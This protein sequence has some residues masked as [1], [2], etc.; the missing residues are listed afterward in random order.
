VT[1]QIIEINRKL[2]SSEN[3]AVAKISTQHE[4]GM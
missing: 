4:A 3:I 1:G 2:N